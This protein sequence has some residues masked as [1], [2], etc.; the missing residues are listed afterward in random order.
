MVVYYG[1]G[2]PVVDSF[3]ITAIGI[4]FHT[5]HTADE[6]LYVGSTKVNIG[7]TEAASAIA[8]IMQVVPAME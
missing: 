3:E 4:S 7:Y 1:T 8:S 6:P 2:T 5:C